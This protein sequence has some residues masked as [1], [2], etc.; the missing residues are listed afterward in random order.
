MRVGR[1]TSGSITAAQL[2]KAPEPAAHQV[3][4]IGPVSDDGAGSGLAELSDD[5]LRPALELAFAV[6][7]AG[8]RLR[9]ALAAP[10]SLRRYLKF[11]KLPNGALTPVR[12]AVD[13]DAGFRER[14]GR[15]ATETLV[16]PAAYLWLL[17][18][19]GWARRLGELEVAEGIESDGPPSGVRSSE[20]RR[21][22]AEAALSRARTELIGL[23]E[24]V[25]RVRAQ[26]TAAEQRAQAA[27]HDVAPLRAEV[28]RLTASAD[29][30]RR[31]AEQ[32]EEAHRRSAGE[33]TA[34]RSRVEELQVSLDA[35]LTARQSAEAA[36]A[37]LAA[38]QSAEAAATTRTGPRTS[39]SVTGPVATTP[40]PLADVSESAA[41]TQ[42][43]PLAPADWMTHGPAL[44]ERLSTV[45]MA[46]SDLGRE[47]LSALP[48]S[49]AAA[50]PV[51]ADDRSGFPPLGVRPLGDRGSGRLR[52]QPIAVP[53]GLL[54][55]SIEVAMFLL[56]QPEV[57]AIVDGY[58]V[59]KFG[60]PD[61]SLADQRDC[62]LDGL[63]DLVR[64]YGM[65]FRVVFD[66]ADVPG[67]VSGRRLIRVQF[68]SAGV[69]ADDEIRGLVYELPHVVPVVVVTNDREIVRAV[70]SE[71][72]NVIASDQLVGAIR[73]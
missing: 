63:E 57:I 56:R 4:T 41:A 7:V 1:V 50:R 18:P 34:A 72:A 24:D 39:K 47:L 65:R 71:G 62:C 38:H 49:A 9:P 23:R 37:A 28:E 73:R 30:R 20:R 59:A 66:G 12:R 25:V 55:D 2:S 29:R 5:Q 32:A 51:S 40:R 31:R 43:G 26:V 68:T 70:R 10:A 14:V 19:E 36:L 52:R 46:L 60:W 15:V 16:G 6:A 42:A 22:A 13:E 58:N 44:A 61:L 64:R 11:Q 48:P 54:G 3:G 8:T 53:G 33:L 35:A 17:R 67:V 21:D 69:S 45:A 27:E